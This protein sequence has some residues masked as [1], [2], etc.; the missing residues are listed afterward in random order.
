MQYMAGM[1]F[2]HVQVH[3]FFFSFQGK[4]IHVSMEIF[5]VAADLDLRTF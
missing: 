5:F 1:K 2:N 3:A 4:E